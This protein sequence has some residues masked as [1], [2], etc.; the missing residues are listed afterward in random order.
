M[1]DPENI[2]RLPQLPPDEMTQEEHAAAVVR[3][4]QERRNDPEFVARLRW[5]FDHDDGDGA[6]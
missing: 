3:Q 6:A 4:I 2:I 1:T 5:L